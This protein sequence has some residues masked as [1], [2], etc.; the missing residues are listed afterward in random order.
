MKNVFPVLLIVFISCS[1]SDSQEIERLLSGQWQ[2]EPIAW[3][4]DTITEMVDTNFDPFIEI[5]RIVLKTDSGNYQ[6]NYQITYPNDSLISIEPYREKWIA[7]YIFEDE[8]S[9]MLYHYT[10]DEAQVGGMHPRLFGETS[11]FK[12]NNEGSTPKIE[13]VFEVN[14]D[15]LIVEET[16]V[17]LTSDTLITSNKSDSTIYTRVD[18]LY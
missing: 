8:S 16:I 10:V 5:R 11:E 4:G 2:Y 15:K 18:N 7:E 3:K 17:K 14:S 1:N 13:I 12:I 9:G 6:Y